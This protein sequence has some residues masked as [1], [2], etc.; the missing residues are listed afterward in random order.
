MNALEILK[1]HDDTSCILLYGDTS[2]LVLSKDLCFREFRVALADILHEAGYDNV[3]FYDSTNASGKFVYDDESAY[4]TGIAR[5]EYVKKHGTI[6]SKM[7]K[8]MTA[9]STIKKT[10]TIKQ[11]GMPRKKVSQPVSSDPTQ[12]T[13]TAD[14]VSQAQMK[15][16]QRNM[17]EV[18]FHGELETY[19]KNDTYRSAVILTDINNFLRN[20]AVK[21][22]FSED[23]RN[24]W[25]KNNLLIFIHPDLSFA[26]NR[27]F[28]QLLRSIGLLEYFYDNGN[29]C[30]EDYTPKKARVFKIEQFFEDEITYL[31]KLGQIQYGFH[32]AD[33]ITKTAEKIH[34]II[35]SQK[36]SERIS[37]RMLKERMLK[38]ALDHTGADISNKDIEKILGYR[39]QDIDFNPWETLKSRR[40]W[41][42]IV[43]TLEAFLKNNASEQEEKEPIPSQKTLFVKRMGGRDNQAEYYPGSNKLPHI[44][45]E[46]SPGTGKTTSIKQIGRILHDEGFLATGHVVPASRA[47][48]IG[49]VIGAT[50]IK[51]REMVA[52]AEGG[53]L[54][55]DEAHQLCENNDDKG[56]GGI[57]AKEAVGQLVKCMTD[58][59]TNVLFVFAG[60]RSTKGFKDGV[61]GLFEMDPGLEDRIKI[62]ITIP[63]YKPEILVDIFLST[64]EKKGYQLG[65]DLTKKDL[66]TFMTNI[67]Q[68]RNRRTF[69]NGRYV[70][71]VLIE[72]RLIKHAVSRGD[73]SFI[74]KEDFGELQPKFEQ[75]TL[76]KVKEEFENMP[77]LG[78]IGISIAEKYINFRQMKIDDGVAVDKIPGCKHMILVGNPGTGKT[79]LVNMLCRA[80]GAANIMSGLDAVIVDTPIG[81]R[82][83]DLKD[84]IKEAVNS[85][86]ILFIDEAHDS[87]EEILKSLLHEMSENKELTC[88]FAVYPNRLTEFLKKA[89][90][91]R[92]RC[93]KPYIISDYT[94]EQMYEIFSAECESEENRCICTDDFSEQLKVL[95]RNWYHTKDA[96][97]DF[98]NARQVIS[99]FEETKAKHY[100]RVGR[101]SYKTECIHELSTLDI[102]DEYLG[103][104]EAQ[105]GNRNFED[106]MTEMDKYY[107][108]AEL[109]QWLKTKHT[110]L[111]LKKRGL[112]KF[113]IKMGN[114]CFVGGPGTGKSTSGPLFAEACYALGLTSTS[115]FK[116]YLAKDLISGYKGQTAQKIA[117]AMEAGK[118]GVI[119][120][121][122][123]YALTPDPTSENNDFEN[124]AVN[125]LLDFTEENRKDT[126]VILAGYED[127]IKQ[128]L[129][130]NIG[131]NDRF[132]IKIRFPNFSADECTEILNS[133]LEQYIKVSDEC[134]LVEKQMFKS[135]CNLS[136]FAN[137]RTV[138]NIQNEIFNAF[139]ER[140]T[141]NMDDVNENKNL[142]EYNGILESIVIPEDIENGFLSWQ[143][144]NG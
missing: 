97:D 19:M 112:V 106:V 49:D 120:I 78:E 131:L 2:D 57:F 76:E 5:E 41:E 36:E 122:E 99:L 121:D 60:Y 66:H 98:S 138:R 45:L 40:G 65:A 18:V 1:K 95:F 28:F 8:K 82:V 83:D 132:P 87:S 56:N 123:A 23:I 86:T 55:V 91:F 74:L 58:E 37:M 27:E 127:R 35:K 68:T 136:Q 22:K 3:V 73:S 4:Y 125:Y 24:T 12:S 81:L 39:L 21:D 9:D 26:Q 32:Y 52:K 134:I 69:S 63:D 115:K 90:G 16:Q 113:P 79:T 48:L 44:M 38:Y 31:L 47:D 135:V 46:G 15:Y 30:E 117:A 70:T 51:V 14:P 101:D 93:D 61:K 54:F 105:S 129:A 114:M 143:K 34:Y 11:F 126:I 100:T 119:L 139:S 128:L 116:K 42:D 140:V 111:N 130:S 59:T 110:Q 118:K 6:S 88:A 67:Y 71:E 75:V 7:A 62:K 137:A 133:M 13:S 33:S 104:I 53:V 94:P 107:G 43:V 84:K 96:D 108:W 102:P 64:L 142:P 92:D 124:A 20:S 80:F 17:D 103:I 29:T 50:A 77:G 25:N 89:R 144:L 141:K 10:S 85:N 72:N 109:K